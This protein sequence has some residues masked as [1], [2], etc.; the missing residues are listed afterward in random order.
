MNQELMA[1]LGKAKCPYCGEAQVR[2]LVL[3]QD[4]YAQLFE[5]KEGEATLTMFVDGRVVVAGCRACDAA[6]DPSR[7]GLPETGW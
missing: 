7:A 3:P 2:V 5:T 4:G 1:K 6:F